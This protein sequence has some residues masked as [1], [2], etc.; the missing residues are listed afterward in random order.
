MSPTQVGIVFCL[1]F[2]TLEAFQAVYLGTVFQNVSS[3]LVGAWVFGIS[4]CGCTLATLLVRPNEIVASVR[5]WKTV[6]ALNLFAALTWTSYFAAVQLIEPAVVFTIFSGM[7]PL[8]TIMGARLGL[9]EAASPSTR[10]SQVGH[11]TILISLLVLAAITILGYSGFVRGGM[12][13]ALVGLGLSAFS[14]GCT[15]FVILYSV[16]LNTRGVGP[17]AQ[18]GLRFVL[19]ALVAFT[20]FKFGIDDKAQETPAGELTLIVLVGLAVIAFPLYLVQK[21]VPLVSASVIAAITALGPAMVFV[22]Q[23]FDGRTHYS[24]LTLTGLSIY[25]T[26]ALL[27]VF[28]TIM[29]KAQSTKSAVIYL[30]A[31]TEHSDKVEHVSGQLS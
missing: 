6:V 16:R 2:V 26:G 10:A 18:F 20:A 3:F 22:L 9:P 30:E 24:M 25:M 29:P 8:G 5:A 1:A 21:A 11:L 7:V 28:G 15:A 19:Y 27:A 17:L 4:V 14:G 12:I 31:K 13:D 23:L